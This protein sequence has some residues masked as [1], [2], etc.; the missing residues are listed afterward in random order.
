MISGLK[1]R[2]E[3]YP[4]VTKSNEIPGGQDSA[5][6]QAQR[7]LHSHW[8][9]AGIGMVIVVGS[10]NMGWELQLELEQKSTLGCKIIESLTLVIYIFELAY[11]FFAYRWE[12][13]RDDWVKLDLFLVLFG[14]ITTWIVEPL[15]INEPGNGTPWRPM[16]TLRMAR[17]LRIVKTARIFSKL[18]TFWFLIRGFIDCA[19][20]M[21]YAL[22]LMSATIYVLACLSVELITKHALVDEDAAFRGHV[23][24]H[25]SSLPHALLTLVRFATLDNTSEVYSLFIQ[26]DPGL[27]LYF[28]FVIM[29]VSLIL[30]HLVGAVVFSS[31]LDNNQKEVDDEKVA[32]EE[33]LTTLI[34]NLREMFLRLDMDKSGQVSTEEIMNINPSDMALLRRA[35][36]ITQ[37]MEV[38]TA[39]DVDNSGE[40]SINEFFDGVLDVA[41]ARST[42]DQKR[43]EKQVETLHWRVK[44]MFSS[45]HDIKLQ[46]N[47]VC[48][49]LLV[50]TGRGADLSADSTDPSMNSHASHQA[51]TPSKNSHAS[52]QGKGT[53]RKSGDANNKGLSEAVDLPDWARE[54]TEELQRSLQRCT[55]LCEMRVTSK[56]LAQSPSPPQVVSAKRSPSPRTRAPSEDQSPSPPS[57][58]N[59]SGMH[60]SHAS[61]HDESE[62]AEEDS[63]SLMRP[64]TVRSAIL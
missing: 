62:G 14:I 59:G 58:Q 29:T 45:L 35:M 37:P 41:V 26:K 19:T 15:T 30:F 51:S 38:F 6:L 4:P 11:R 63:A 47:R 2:K 9:D 27:V 5:R 44:E 34:C 7:V 28:I 22:I 10:L 55:D 3:P 23:E 13:L 56:T 17:L 57:Y 24:L 64:A 1:K 18:Q 12:A 61:P 16:M 52:H 40:I 43:I 54:I 33:S 20:L 42:V 53:P 39:L 32:Q 60:E 25:F 31:L 8:F 46:M 21:V 48:E 49:E 36:G 50:P